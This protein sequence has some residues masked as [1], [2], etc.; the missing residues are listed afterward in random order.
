M[1]T[2]NCRP[3]KAGDTVK[4][5]YRAKQRAMDACMQIAFSCYVVED[6]AHGGLLLTSA[7]LVKLI[8]QSLYNFL[9]IRDH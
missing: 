7:K 6:S 2:A 3:T 4:P 1:Y 9:V 8:T 5:S